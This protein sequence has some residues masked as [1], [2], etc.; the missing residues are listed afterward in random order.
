MLQVANRQSWQD[1][2]KYFKRVIDRLGMRID[3][4]IMDTVVALNGAGVYTTASCEGHLH[5]AAPYPWIRV[6]HKDADGIAHQIALLL[7]D[8]KREDEETQRLMKQHR[9]L[10]LEEEQK[11]ITL[12]NAFYQE[13]QF[14]YDRHLS[15]WRYAN[16]IPCVQS[17]GSDHQ[18]FRSCD[19]KALKLKEYQQEMQDFALFLKN[20]FFEG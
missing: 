5:R 17:F 3:K 1:L 8:G 20:K 9:A 6:E 10:L 2:H 12:L 18:E 13:H 4:G 11:L 15:I 19:E 16:G 14:D 7:H